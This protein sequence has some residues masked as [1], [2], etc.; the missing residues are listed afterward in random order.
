[1]HRHAAEL[2]ES[3]RDNPR[4]IAMIIRL[5]LLGDYGAAARSAGHKALGF[6]RKAKLTRLTQLAAKYE[7]GM[8]SAAEVKDWNRLTKTQ[9][10]RLDRAILAELRRR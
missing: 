10:Q 4:H 7:F 2:F 8:S 9:Q 5:I 6:S 1:M 3:M